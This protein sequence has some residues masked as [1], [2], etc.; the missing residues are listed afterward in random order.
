M[1]TGK[2][3]HFRNIAKIFLIILILIGGGIIAIYP[4]KL[5]N[6]VETKT[7]ETAVKYYQEGDTA[8]FVKT[9]LQVIIIYKYV[10]RDHKYVYTVVYYDNYD[11]RRQ[12]TNVM[13]QELCNYDD[14]KWEKIIDTINKIR[15]NIPI[16]RI[17]CK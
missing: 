4:S 14:I 8:Y 16:N 3:Q 6:T 9:G 17:R 1:I 10:S 12:A 11:D 5:F 7:K 2:K 13:P 15:N